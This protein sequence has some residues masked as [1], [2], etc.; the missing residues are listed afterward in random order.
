MGGA[1]A[2][3]VYSGGYQHWEI[4]KSDCKHKPAV[5]PERKG[6]GKCCAKT[7][8]TVRATACS[9]SLIMTPL[10][11]TCNVVFY[12]WQYKSKSCGSAW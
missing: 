11:E 4:N 7:L 9:Y 12:A 6:N 3:P 8:K 10:G 2:T 1:I 5:H